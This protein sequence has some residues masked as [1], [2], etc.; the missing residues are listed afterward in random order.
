MI[1]LRSNFSRFP[2]YAARKYQT[3]DQVRLKP[4]PAITNLLHVSATPH[5]DLTFLCIVITYVAEFFHAFASLDKAEVT[6]RRV[7]KFATMLSG[8]QCVPDGF[9]GGVFL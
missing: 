1:L 8:I 5:A 7:E 6:A 4:Q 9:R 3:N 2:T